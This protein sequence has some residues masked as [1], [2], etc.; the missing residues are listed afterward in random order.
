MAPTEEKRVLCE[1]T[2]QRRLY[3]EYKTVDAAL[4]NQL[5]AVFDNPYLETLKT[6]TQGTQQGRQWTS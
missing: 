3:N 5:L 6:G 2:D 1:Y 4:K